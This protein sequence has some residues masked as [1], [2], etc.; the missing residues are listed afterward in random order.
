MT[1]TNATI[2]LQHQALTPLNMLTSMTE[3]LYISNIL[4][5]EPLTPY[6]RLPLRS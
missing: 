1:S 2:N 5:P 6:T 4:Q 3:I